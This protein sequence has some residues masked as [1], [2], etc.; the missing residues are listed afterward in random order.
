MTIENLAPLFVNAGFEIVRKERFESNGKFVSVEGAYDDEHKY[1]RVGRSIRHI[2]R[3]Q[4]KPYEDY[5]N[6]LGNLYAADLNK[7][8]PMYNSLWC[9]AVKPAS[10][11]YVL[12]V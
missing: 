3:N 6:S 11:D 8:E 9:D 5:K 12:S 7:G 4:K 1:G 10:C 2:V